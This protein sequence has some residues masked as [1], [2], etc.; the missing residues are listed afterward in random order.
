MSDLEHLKDIL[1]ALD[2][3]RRSFA[4]RTKDIDSYLTVS[5]DLLEAAVKAAEN[6]SAG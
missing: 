5:R 4:R 2:K 6:R 1:A 3:R